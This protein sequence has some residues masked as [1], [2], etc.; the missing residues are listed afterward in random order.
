MTT[1]YKLGLLAAAVL[2]ACNAENAYNSK[3][4]DSEKLP[5]KTP[6]AVNLEVYLTFDRPTHH[7]TLNVKVDDY[8]EIT[9]NFVISND[10]SG[11]VLSKDGTVIPKNK[12]SN[13]AKMA[14][15]SSY[16]K[17]VILYENGKPIITRKSTPEKRMYASDFFLMN[18]EH[19]E[20]EYVYEA[21]AADNAG[22]NSASSPL[23]LVFKNDYTYPK[24]KVTN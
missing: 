11:Y 20:G 7:P 24:E 2:T 6:P 1:N 12:S 9:Y 17:E 8:D 5:D 19:K 4:N 22:N 10:D 3:T 16:L 15:N 13:V 23:V 18:L 21:K 14:G